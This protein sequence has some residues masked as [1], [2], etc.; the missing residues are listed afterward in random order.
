M[1]EIISFLASRSED[2]LL[3]LQVQSEAAQRFSMSLAEIEKIALSNA[4]L[5]ARYQRNRKMITTRQQLTLLQSRVVV[6]GCG[7][8][9]GYIIE[10]MARLGIGQIIAVDPDV[11]EEHNL[12]RQLFSSPGVLG[13]KKVD[14]AMKRVAEI[15]PAVEMQP[16]CEALNKNNSPEIIRGM[17]VAADALDSVPDRKMLARMCNQLKIPLV[18]GAIAGWYGHLAT[19]FPGDQTLE[20]I[21]QEDKEPQGIETELGNPSFTPAVIASLQVAEIVKIILGTGENLRNKYF[22]IDLYHM[23]INTFPLNSREE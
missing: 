1:Q 22:S 2:G 23:E 8:L 18:H 7:G 21:Y 6:V 12:N 9:G 15:N 13:E 14:V 17:D 3:P 11:F 5:P 4:I 16:I 19:Q 10:E 20:Q